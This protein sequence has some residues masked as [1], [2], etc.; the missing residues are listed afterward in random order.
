NLY[1]LTV[2]DIRGTS[3]HVW[4]AWKGRLLDE[5]FHSTTRVL[6]LDQGAPLELEARIHDAQADALEQVDS[7]SIEPDVVHRYWA[8]LPQDY[9]LRHSASEIAWHA[10]VL[11]QA[12]AISLPIVSIRHDAALKADLIFVYAAESELLLSVVTSALTR[13][14]FNIAD[15]RLQQSNTGFALYTFIALASN[16]DNTRDLD[17][18]RRQLRDLIVAGEH[19]YTGVTQRLSRTQKHFPIATNVNFTD[20][21]AHYTVMEIV[22]QD[23][24][25]LLHRVAHC[26]LQCKVRLINAKIATYGE[27][28][29]DVFFISDRDGEPVNDTQQR[30]CLSQKIK[31]A[32]DPALPVQEQKVAGL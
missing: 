19:E 2:A 17:V 31:Q 18:L 14:K 20:S 25:G 24:P 26:L 30:N 3:P 15:A 1:I 23:Q 8:S 10:T 32:L 27:R 9:F 7:K 21:S 4:N 6:R 28:V 16:S 11:A 13:L 22:A 29:E 12:S 5:L